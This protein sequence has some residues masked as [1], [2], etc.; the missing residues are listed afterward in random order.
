MLILYVVFAC[1]TNCKIIN[2]VT[3]IINKYRN[4][5]LDKDDP[6]FKSW[7]YYYHANYSQACY[8]FVSF[9]YNYIFATKLLNR[10]SSDRSTELVP[11]NFIIT[12]RHTL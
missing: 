10:T 4:K 11:F 2:N 9:M 6:N 7:W 12:L 5:I 8:F 3:A 1:T